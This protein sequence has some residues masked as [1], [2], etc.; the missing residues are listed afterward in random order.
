MFIVV[1]RAGLPEILQELRFFFAG[2][3]VGL[4]FD[5]CQRTQFLK[6]FI[7]PRTTAQKYWSIWLRVFWHEALE[8]RMHN[9]VHRTVKGFAGLHPPIEQPTPWRMFLHLPIRRLPTP[10]DMSPE[11][12]LV[13]WCCLPNRPGIKTI[14]KKENEGGSPV[15]ADRHWIRPTPRSLHA[16]RG[17]VK[18][19]DLRLCQIM[20]TGDIPLWPGLRKTG[21]NFDQVLL[22][23]PG[24]HGPQVRTGFV[25]RS[26]W[27]NP[28]LS[29]RTLVNPVEE[30]SNLF[31]SKSFEWNSISPFRPFGKCRF[32]LG[33]CSLCRRSG[34]EVLRNRGF[35]RCRHCETPL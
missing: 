14:I 28:V 26:T 34:A 4:W 5:L 7:W 8:V 31:A 22:P 20:P 9:S 21:R 27:I 13:E 10:A 3:K 19:V 24:D 2:F 29:D 17:K 32:V 18:R 33:P 12:R 1:F 23:R 25:R 35:E 6:P 11:N 30:R 15:S 16:V